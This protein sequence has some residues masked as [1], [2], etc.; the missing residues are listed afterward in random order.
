MLVRLRPG[1]GEAWFNMALSEAQLG[2]L[3]AARDHLQR[4]LEAGPPRPR[5]L[6]LLARIL[7]FQGRR[8][9]ATAALKRSLELDP[10]QP[11]FREM[12][13][14]LLAGPDGP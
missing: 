14:R 3:D 9:E 12:L 1:D 6:N 8:D 5:I 13:D 7:E 4:A 10:E 11:R 2:E